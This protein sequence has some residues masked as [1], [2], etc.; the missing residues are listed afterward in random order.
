MFRR[1]L[2]DGG[3]YRAV[4]SGPSTVDCRPSTSPR[5]WPSARCSPAP[6]PSAPPLPAAPSR[7]TRRPSSAR[8]TG[9]LMAFWE[10]AAGAADRGFL[11]ELRLNL[12]ARIA[13]EGD[14]AF[15]TYGTG[16]QVRFVRED[17]L[18]RIESPE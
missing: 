1:R 15:M 5:S 17:G 11:R 3:L 4:D 13:E 8:T 6:A 9:Q 2:P 14:E 7:P 16:R 12:Y 10:G 18:W